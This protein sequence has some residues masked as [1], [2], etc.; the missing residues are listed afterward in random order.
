MA[1][2]INHVEIEGVMFEVKNIPLDAYNVAQ[3]ATLLFNHGHAQVR[4]L[5]KASLKVAFV[6]NKPCIIEGILHGDHIEVIGLRYKEK[7]S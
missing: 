7:P 6:N 4:V 1:S 2:L 3:I 5:G